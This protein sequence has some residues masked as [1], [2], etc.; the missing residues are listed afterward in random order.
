MAF[1]KLDQ[2]GLLREFAAADP[3]F[4]FAAVQIRAAS[5]IRTCSSDQAAESVGLTLD[6]MAIEALDT[7]RVGFHRL[8]SSPPSY[9]TSALNGNDIQNITFEKPELSKVTQLGA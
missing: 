7:I 8:A 9:R 3:C 5:A 1:C 2:T 4:K 6:V